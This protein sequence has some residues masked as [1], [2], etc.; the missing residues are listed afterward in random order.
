[1]EAG[2]QEAGEDNAQL[3]RLTSRSDGNSKFW[4]KS[5]YQQPFLQMQQPNALPRSHY[6][7]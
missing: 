5:T 1:M 6:R 4:T 2:R 7:K 3:T